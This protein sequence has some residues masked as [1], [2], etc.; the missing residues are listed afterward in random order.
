MPITRS[1]KRTA[2]KRNN[3]VFVYISIRYKHDEKG[4]T[5]RKGR[6]LNQVTT[7][8]RQLLRPTIIV[9]N[10][11][12]P[13]SIDCMLPSTTRCH[14]LSNR[15]SHLFTKTPHRLQK[16]DTIRVGFSKPVT[17]STTL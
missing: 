6:I 13:S 10:R 8:D 12:L 5:C 11:K 3:T 2:L 7:E 17:H 1:Q 16:M 15:T 14:I 4:H 9:F